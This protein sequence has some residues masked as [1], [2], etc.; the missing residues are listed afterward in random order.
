M[1]QKAHFFFFWE[2][3][4]HFRGQKTP[5]APGPNIRGKALMDMWDP[6]V[7]P[8][9]SFIIQSWP[10]E[11]TST[12]NEH[13]I[14]SNLETGNTPAISFYK[15]SDFNWIKRLAQGGGSQTN[16]GFFH[17]IMMPLKQAIKTNNLKPLKTAGRIFVT[18]SS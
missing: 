6:T 3:K 4:P 11:V 13:L 14:H 8:L 12:S 17:Y 15:W 2:T 7:A 10:L 1:P 5:S 9:Y 18:M 16:A